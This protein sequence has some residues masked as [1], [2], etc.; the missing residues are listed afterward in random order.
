MVAKVRER[1]TVITQKFDMER[2]NL[3]ELDGV[4]GKKQ[5]RVKI[6]IRFAALKNDDVD[7]NRA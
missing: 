4:E 5:Y 2:F 3:M 6:S 7:I 1:L